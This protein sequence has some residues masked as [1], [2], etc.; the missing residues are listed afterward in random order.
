VTELRQRIF[1]FIEYVNKTMAKPFK[2]TD[3]DVRWSLK[4]ERHLR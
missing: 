4:S 2:W 1:A 3:A